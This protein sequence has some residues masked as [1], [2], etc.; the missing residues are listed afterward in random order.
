MLIKMV[1]QFSTVQRIFMVSKYFETKSFVVTIE[2]F[3]RQ[4]PGREPPTK[5]TIFR[6]VKKYKNNGSS[7]NLNKGRS[8]RPRTTR[9]DANIERV[10]EVFTENPN[11]STRR[12]PVEVSQS[13]ISRIL[14]LELRWHPYKIHVRQELKEQD[15]GRRVRFCRWFLDQCQN[16]RF[17]H[18]LVIGDEAS[19]SLNGKVNTQCVRLYAPK[20]GEHPSF[21]FEK[22]SSR[23]KVNVWAGVCGNGSLLGPFFFEGNINGRAY[24]EMINEQIVPAL[25]RVYELPEIGA[26]QDIWWAQDGAPA[27]RNREVI[28]RI[29]AIFRENIIALGHVVEWPPRSPDLTPLDFSLWGYLKSKVFTTPPTNLE[30]LRE[31]IIFH[32]NLLREGD[33]IVNSIRG[34]RRR[35]NICIQ[36]D[37]RQVEGF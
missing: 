22:N 17:L 6:N 8:G 7:L 30:E 24:L 2:E 27:H 31:R 32:C 1:L 28:A 35:A 18:N 25:L 34:M 9:T 4:F 36:R 5:M 19:F 37:G 29:R 16:N 20:N 33:F 21:N 3:R 12:N 23:E 10:R 15:F 11:L 14:R 26:I 13:S